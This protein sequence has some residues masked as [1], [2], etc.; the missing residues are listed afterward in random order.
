MSYDLPA[1]SSRPV[2]RA[3][4]PYIPGYGWAKLALAGF[5]LMLVAVSV[6]EF[7]TFGRL[8]VSGGQAQAVATRIIQIDP[9][10][11]ETVLATDAEVRAAEKAVADSRDRSLVFWGE[12]R[13]TTETGAVVDVR[14]P[15]GQIMKPLQPLRDLDGLPSTLRLWYDRK[16]PETV[17]IPFQFLAG[18]WYPFGFS[19]FF[20]PGMFLLFG[21]VGTAMGLLLWWNAKRVIDMPDLSPRPA[22]PPANH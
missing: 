16:H 18:T 1:S 13:F 11:T 12:Y 5:G 7:A 22:E 15:I 17:V 10:G 4:I 20:I 6:A 19:T 8:A 9:G 2:H 21:T 14:S 3:V